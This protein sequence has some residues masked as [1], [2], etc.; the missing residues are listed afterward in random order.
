[1][2]ADSPVI[3]V[4][5][6]TFNRARLLEGALDSVLAQR[7]CPA[8]EVVVTDDGSTDDT[9]RLLSRY[10]PALCVVRRAQNGGVAVARAAGVARARGTL[11]AFH[12]S[13]DLMLP[14]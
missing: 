7:E 2:L 6:P 14:G 9:A 10:G 11:L 3:S 8:F 4:I 5:L 13:D 1:M 12:D